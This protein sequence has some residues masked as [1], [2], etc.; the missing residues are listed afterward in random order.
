MHPLGDSVM[1]RSRLLSAIEEGH[2]KIAFVVGS[3][4]TAGVI[5]DVAKM[6]QLMKAECGE[7]GRLRFEKTHEVADD[8][9]AEYREVADFLF[10]SKGRDALNRV[11]QSAV[12]EAF[13]GEIPERLSI[14]QTPLQN[15]DSMLD[16]RLTRGVRYL[17]KILA[18]LP[19]D[20]RGPIITTNFDPLIEIAVLSAGGIPRTQIVDTEGRFRSI[21]SGGVVDI[22]HVH[23]YWRDSDTLSMAHQ[24]STARPQL[25][26]SIRSELRG[27]DTFVIGYGGWDDVFTR[28]LRERI[29]LG[30]MDGMDILW[31]SYAELSQEDLGSELFGELVKS[32]NVA[33]YSGIDANSILPYVYGRLSAT[34]TE[35]LVTDELAGWTTV[36]RSFIENYCRPLTSD[37]RERFFDGA[38]PTWS[39]ASDDVIPRLRPARELMAEVRKMITGG[40]AKRFVLL[41]GP[42]GEGKSTAFRQAAVS[43]GADRESEA[44]I[45]WREVGADLNI[46]DVLLLPSSRG[47]HVLFVEDADLVFD[48]LKLLSAR[49]DAEKRSDIFVVLSAQERDWRAVRGFELYSRNSSYVMAAG[50]NDGDARLI[51]KSWYTDPDDPKVAKSA[52]S[53]VKSSNRQRGADGGSLIGAML[54]IRGGETLKLRIRELF[55]RLERHN[56]EGGTSLT[57]AFAMIAALSTETG[58]GASSL[59]KEIL[60]K[61]FQL[62]Q[63]SV[64]YVILDP[65]GKEAMATWTENTVRTRHPMIALSVISMLRERDKETLF[66]AYRGV[67]RG[68]VAD[69]Q[70]KQSFDSM[71]RELA[72]LC[73]SLEYE[74][75]ALVAIDAAIDSAP[76]RLTFRTSKVATLRRFKQLARSHNFALSVYKSSLEEYSD[77][78]SRSGF[79]TDWAT[80][81]GLM[82]HYMENIALDLAALTE[83]GYEEY[84]NDGEKSNVRRALSGM[85][86]AMTKLFSQ[87]NQSDLVLAVRACAELVDEL[88]PDREEVVYCA[89]HLAFAVKCGSR[90]KLGARESVL[91]LSRAINSLEFGGITI[92]EWDIDPTMPVLYRLFDVERSKLV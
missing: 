3:G 84:L 89:T 61:A 69:A 13:E 68:A 78:H 57:I 14:D 65:L 85:A 56:T 20:R 16:W 37:E 49:L 33:L 92:D 88:G 2:K 75:E 34:F 19:A 29:A 1:F 66:A 71:H 32:N 82:H 44:S 79:Y 7:E 9:G 45:Y 54:A 43:L 10:M 36:T 59:S 63:Y 28:S 38:E 5:P 51:A 72:Y 15:L 48:R 91:A 80:T 77:Q 70:E 87:T 53:I 4:L 55:N 50:V 30:N 86:V 8:S 6:I 60:A 73:N 22:V 52:D 23:G 26:D 11:I 41:V 12:L 25:Q 18:A 21:S 24:L 67:V 35:P 83:I 74:D 17:G 42:M 47:P 31:S 90:E 81:A 27:T 58:V 76:D 46:E 40:V 39:V 62:D 64:D